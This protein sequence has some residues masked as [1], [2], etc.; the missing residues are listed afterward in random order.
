MPL[1]T[2]EL[3]VLHD[4]FD[5]PRE[6]RITMLIERMASYGWRLAARREAGPRLTAMRWRGK[7]ILT[8]E[9]GEDED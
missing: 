2:K 6:D 1:A 4:A 5:E 3:D 7:T 8:F 9:R